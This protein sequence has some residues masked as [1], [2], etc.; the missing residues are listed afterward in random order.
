M[1]ALQAV[2]AVL[3]QAAD[4]PDDIGYVWA[5]YGLAVVLIVAYAVLTIRRG[6]AVSRQLPPEERRWM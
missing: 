4:T 5:A 1:F 3:A 2:A 6:R